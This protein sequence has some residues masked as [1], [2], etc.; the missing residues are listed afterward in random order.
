MNRQVTALIMREGRIDFFVA[1]GQR[2]PGLNRVYSP[3]LAAR[4]LEA[5]GM[6]DTRQRSSSSSRLVGSPSLRRLSLDAQSLLQ[7]DT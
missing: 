2:Y 7:T 3:T 6:G 4:L 5:F 1:V